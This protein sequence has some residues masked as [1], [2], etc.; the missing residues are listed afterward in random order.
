MAWKEKFT[1]FLLRR[2]AK[3]QGFLD[4]MLLLSRLQRFSQ[5]AEVWVPTE[6]LRLGSVMQ[7]RGVINSQA[8]QHN[9]DWVWPFWV[10]HQ[11]APKDTAFIPR[12]FSLS[13]INLTHRNWTAVGVPDFNEYPLVDPRGLVTLF[14][15]GWSIDAWI[16]TADQPSLFPSQAPQASQTIDYQNGVNIMTVT[17]LERTTLE[18]KCWVEMHEGIPM[19]KIQLTANAPLKSTLV[20]S[21][22]PY[23]PEGVSFINTITQLP[24][25][26]G[27]QVDGSKNV[28]LQEKPQRYIFS[29]Y[30]MGDLSQ[31]IPLSERNEN[32]DRQIT[33]PVGMASAA[34]AY[35][36]QPFQSKKTTVQIPLSTAAVPGAG[37]WDSH[38]EGHCQ[39]D[40]PDKSFQFLYDVALRTLVLHSPGDVYPGPFTY[41]R[42]WFRDAA[43]IL[44]A[45]MAAGLFKNVEKI[46]DHFPSRQT[47]LG[48]FMSQDGEWDSNGQAIWVMQRFLASTHTKVKPQWSKSI[49]RAAQWIQRKRVYPKEQAPHAGL[50]PAG[51]SAEHFGPNDYYYWD[52]FW[53][54]AGLR[55]A[56][57]AIDQEHPDLADEF[58]REAND[59][60]ECVDESLKLVQLRTNDLAVPASPYRRMDG[61]AIGALAASY[62][63]QLWEPRD[64]RMMQTIEYFLKNC[65]V[66]GGFYHEISHSGIN[67]YLT[68]HVAQVL[69]RAGDMRFLDVVR[70]VA[71]LATSTGQWPEAIHPQT[72][73]GCMGDGQHVW[74]AA[75]WVQM[76]RN[77]FVLEEKDKLILCAGIPEDWIKPHKSVYFGFTHTAFGKI[78]VKI[79]RDEH[80]HVSWESAWHGKAPAVEV[81]LPGYPAKTIPEGEH[82]IEFQKKERSKNYDTAKKINV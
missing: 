23:N 63:L 19:C 79:T 22:R 41:K 70:A 62:P 55:A 43:F 33:C 49:I 48:Y 5:P 68:L 32:Q 69:L 71:E 58:E 64:E 47:P 17:K 60:L 57:L 29:N 31:Q 72:K 27:W 78:A 18:S 77:M 28:Y 9:M 75:E 1:S 24:Y 36:V 20:V 15:D 39:L 10:K 56:V 45:M 11:F 7:A 35:D 73:G 3:A 25:L 16:M 74:A 4:P 80:I 30:S 53:S 40:I 61:G 2:L 44:N 13:H 42:F 34:A 59:L 12:A 81:R 14:W 50:L 76:I 65:F 52:D 51:F 26:E 21:V 37:S 82:S 46:M 6:L 67:A 38:L 8:I 66:D 54:A